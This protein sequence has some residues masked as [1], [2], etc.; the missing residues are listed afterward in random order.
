M[1]DESTPHPQMPKGFTLF[2][3]MVAIF[4]FAIVI[5]M[6]FGSLGVVLS[7]T[8]AIK[9]RVD[10]AETAKICIERMVSDLQSIYLELPPAYLPPE[11]DAPPDPYRIVGDK[12]DV[13][14]V[15]FSRLRF[16]SH[17]HLPFKQ[18]H[19]SDGIAEIVYYV[20]EDDD[21]SIVLRRSD[22]LYPYKEFEE[23]ESDP[24]LCEAIRSLE[25]KF[26][27]EEGEE[28]D[29]W[30]SESPDFKYATPRAIGLLLET[31]NDSAS[32]TYDTRVSLR[33]YRKKKG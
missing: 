5:T 4:I 23:N 32:E 27:D 31:G 15:D 21:G 7:G 20:Q 6:L 14:T 12:T 17:A 8:K 10:L 28:Y 29:N 13:N 25:F 11:F 2:E 16:T 33:V 26:Y 22:R 1:L 24:L 18:D 3:I 30:D 19:A 9:E